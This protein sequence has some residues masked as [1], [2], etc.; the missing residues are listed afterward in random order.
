MCSFQMRATS[1]YSLT[2]LV[3]IAYYNMERIRLEWSHIWAVM[4]EHFNKVGCMPNV[5]I[6]N[7]AVDALRQLSM[8]FLE[9]GELANYSFQKDFLRPF[10]CVR[11]RIASIACN[12]N[13]SGLVPCLWH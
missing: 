8:K 13:F 9:K 2:K 12:L 10:E 4:G 5:E 3:E 6:A 1:R 7:A 11:S